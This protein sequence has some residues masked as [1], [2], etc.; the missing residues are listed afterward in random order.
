MMLKEKNYKIN[1]ALTDSIFY[2]R[3]YSYCHGLAGQQETYQIHK[4]LNPE[5]CIENI[6]FLWEY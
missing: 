4:Q 2:C 6:H 3:H 1:L 5:E